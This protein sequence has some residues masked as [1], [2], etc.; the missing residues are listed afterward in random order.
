M[1]SP[2]TKPVENH[3]P[4]CGGRLER[5]LIDQTY[6]IEG[7]SVHVSDLMPYRCQACQTLVW[8]EAELK[9]A[10]QAVALKRHKDAA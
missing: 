5:E 9:R 8:T 1:S 6:T 2:S 7:Q 4:E 3:C 10:R